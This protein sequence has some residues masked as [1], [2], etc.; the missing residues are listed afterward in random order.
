MR[1]LRITLLS[2]ILFSLV[3]LTPAFAHCPLCTAATG[4][5]VLVTRSYGIDDLAVGTFMGGFVLSTS[6]WSD[7]ILKKRNK[8]SQYIPLQGLILT[9]FGLLFTLITFYWANLMGPLLPTLYG[10]NKLFLGTL[11]GTAVAFSGFELHKLIRNNM[12]RS[13]IPF[14][15]IVLTLLSLIVVNIGFYLVNWV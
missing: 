5:A 6:L 12:Q 8:G 13:I 15:G 7:R 11:V 14:Q 9:L 3:L 10:L 2:S 1:S 4:A